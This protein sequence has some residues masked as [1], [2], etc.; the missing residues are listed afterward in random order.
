MADEGI[1][2]T[3]KEVIEKLDRKMDVM[4]SVLAS[5][6]DRAELSALDHRVNSVENELREKRAAKTA[7]TEVRKESKEHWRWLLPVLVSLAGVSLSVLI[8]LLHL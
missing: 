7:V 3:L 1:G 6:A 2:Y 4:F 5:K 8:V